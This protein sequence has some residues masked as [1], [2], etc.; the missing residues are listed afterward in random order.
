MIDNFTICVLLYGDH[1]DLAQRCL[2]SLLRD[3]AIPASHL[4]IGLNAV[5]DRSRELAY[6][7]A[8]GNVWEYNEN[9]H[10]YPVMRE[11]IHGISPIQTPYTMWFDDDSYLEHPSLR[12][13]LVAVDASMQG[14]DMLGSLYSIKWQGKQREFVRSQPWYAGKDP[15]T[16]GEIRFATGGWWTLRSDLLYRFDYP[17]TFLDHRG[18]DAMLGELCHQQNLRLK[19]FRTGVK[20]NA[21]ASG[22]ESKAK[23]RGFD[24]LPIGVDF[25]PGVAAAL[26]TATST[27]PGLLAAVPKPRS[28]II[29]L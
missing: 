27:P 23:R 25:D 18:G 20:I 21:D 26:N 3:G 13:W 12:E 29:E 4:R 14:A 17:W 19:H 7:A 22:R 11:M 6:Q 28:R 8:P 9:C 10:K 16:R 5:C 15:V 1:F 2:G 24:Q